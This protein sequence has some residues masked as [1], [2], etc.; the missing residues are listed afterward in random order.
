MIP[1]E[2]AFWRISSAPC[3]DKHGFS[4]RGILCGT[5]S[6]K[7]N[8]KL[9]RVWRSARDLSGEVTWKWSSTHVLVYFFNKEEFTCA[10]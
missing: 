3:E 10:K 7:V 4:C 8:L 2:V 6:T 1:T 5:P 9:I